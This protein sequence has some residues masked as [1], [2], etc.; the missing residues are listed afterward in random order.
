MLA[1]QKSVIVGAA[2]FLRSP[3]R[4]LPLLLGLAAGAVAFAIYGLVI[5]PEDFVADHLLNHG[6]RRFAVGD[7]SSAQGRMAY[8]SPGELWLEFARHFGWI[9]CVLAAAGLIAA[10]THLVRRRRA[11]RASM[12][13]MSGD[14]AREEDLFREIAALWILVGGFLFTLT[15]WRQTKHLCKLVP[16]MTLVMGALLARSPFPARLVLRAALVFSF[17]WNLR[18]LS[19]ISQDFSSFPMSTIW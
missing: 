10:L 8:P 11:G 9:W 17:V 16:A 6:I 13:P 18:W 5:A 7:A 2:A 12:R 3:R 14:D 19:R 15:D 1:N 4:A